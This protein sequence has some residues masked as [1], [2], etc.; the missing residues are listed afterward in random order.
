MCMNLTLLVAGEPFGGKICTIWDYSTRTALT[1]QVYRHS[2][3]GAQYTDGKEFVMI[4][5]L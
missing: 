5:N 2:H 4:K 3:N 1:N